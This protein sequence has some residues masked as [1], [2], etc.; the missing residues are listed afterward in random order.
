M[1]WAKWRAQAEQALLICLMEQLLNTS[2][3]KSERVNLVM[4]VYHGFQSVSDQL[5]SLKLTWK[6]PFP[7]PLAQATVL[8]CSVA[9]EVEQVMTATVHQASD[10][11]ATLRSRQQQGYFSTA[12]MSVV[13]VRLKG[14][15]SPAACNRPCDFQVGVQLQAFENLRSTLFSASALTR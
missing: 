1:K 3:H 2:L 8:F 4:R 7:E 13:N 5:D 15:M 6:G 14:E 12:N 11:V 9:A 10:L